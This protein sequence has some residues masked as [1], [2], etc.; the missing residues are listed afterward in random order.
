[1]ALEHGFADRK[2][3]RIAVEVGRDP[4]S[5]LRVTVHDNGHGLPAQFEAEKGTSL[6]LAIATT[7]ARGQGGCFRVEPC[8]GTLATLTLPSST[9][10]GA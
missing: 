2:G 3:G 9:L 8:E 4:Q 5:G 10:A 7:L 6:G 1:M